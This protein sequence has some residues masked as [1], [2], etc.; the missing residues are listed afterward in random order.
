M[1]KSVFVA[2]LSMSLLLTACG[3][4]DKCLDLGGRWNEATQ[5]CEK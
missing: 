3:A 2:I 5:S 1:K 4:K